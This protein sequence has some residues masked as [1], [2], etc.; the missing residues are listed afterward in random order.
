M[1]EKAIVLRHRKNLSRSDDLRDFQPWKK[2]RWVYV[3]CIKREN[4]SSHVPLSWTLTPPP[5]IVVWWPPI[6]GASLL[7][8]GF[9]L[10]IDILRCLLSLPIT[11]QPAVVIKT[12]KA[13]LWGSAVSCQPPS[14]SLSWGQVQT[15]LYAVC[16]VGKE[17]C[18]HYAC[19]HRSVLKALEFQALFFYPTI[20]R[21]TKTLINCYLWRADV[22][23]IQPV[24]RRELVLVWLQR[25]NKDKNNNK[26]WR[27]RHILPLQ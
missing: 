9:S 15:G 7:F 27:K 26:K 5:L 1:E 3:P 8:S 20:V 14:F 22:M 24:K 13:V 19:I 2:L 18:R 12:V 6:G 23:V 4:H 16:G 17:W 11:T 21:L 10:L 25:R